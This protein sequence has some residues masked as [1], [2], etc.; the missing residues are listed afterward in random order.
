M[1]HTNS[2]AEA[3][4]QVPFYSQSLSLKPETTRWALIKPNAIFQDSAREAFQQGTVNSG[5]GVQF[6][7]YMVQTSGIWVYWKLGCLGLYS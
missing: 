7:S 1:V 6:G 4:G 5:A 2:K 3:L